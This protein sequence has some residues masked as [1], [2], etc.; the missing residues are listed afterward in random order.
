[1]VTVPPTIQPAFMTRDVIS[2][3]YRLYAERCVEIARHVTDSDS[4]GDF[5]FDGSALACLGG[6]IRQ[7]QPSPNDK[8]R[9]AWA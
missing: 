6:P 4:K 5:A 7:K 3:P 2:P 8:L 9:D 1:M